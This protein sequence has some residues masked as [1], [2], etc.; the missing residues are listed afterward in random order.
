MKKRS[1]GLRVLAAAALAVTVVLAVLQQ[2]RGMDERFFSASIPGAR[3][4]AHYL[5]G[6]YGGAAHWYRVT[7]AAAADPAPKTSWKSLI[8]GNH[9]LAETLARRE[10]AQEPDAL[11]PSLTLAEVAL[12]RREHTEA[13][14]HAGRVLASAPD[15]YDALLITALARTRRSEWN[16][17]L[18]ALKRALRQDR[19]ERRYTLFLTMLE[20]TGD[21]D[22][23]DSPP[24]C[25]LAHL[26]RYLRGHD[27]R[28]DDLAA[29]YARRAIEAGDRADDAWVTVAI[30]DDRRG[31]QRQALAAF[32]RA[33][34]ANPA[35]T[36]ALL[37][38]ADLRARR[39]E[40]AA[41]YGLLRTAFQATPDDPFVADRL[42]D[43]LTRK[44]G[45][46][47]QALAAAETVVSASPDDARAWWRLGV[48][49]AHLGDHPAALRSF[50][51]SIGLKSLP[52]AYEGMGHALGRL[53]RVGEA[54]RAYEQAIQRDPFRAGPFVGLAA[55]HA[56]ERRYAQAVV[57]YERAHRLDGAR[58]LGQ[59]VELCALYHEAG[60]V[61]RALS[62]LREVV[63]RDPDNARGRALLEHVQQSLAN[64]RPA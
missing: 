51:R 47:R 30:V 43:V 26:H 49:Q 61:D 57:A 37:G 15:D 32:D 50:E 3:A 29:W 46:Y 40:L 36:A 34:A 35:N 54:A 17:A 1:V 31:K 14:E 56:R 8:A 20:T 19:T 42:H 4:L 44:L 45:D 38:A 53:Q 58:D 13:L 22:D 23:A 7:A 24:L 41:E 2:A 27:P 25:L 55:L 6:D 28:H 64:R 62:C 59:I 9:A 33:L 10:L 16:E 39:G 21:L 48:V 5:A 52:E 11:T 18:D 60:Q 12:G 63:A